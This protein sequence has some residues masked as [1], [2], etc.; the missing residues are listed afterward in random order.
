MLKHIFTVPAY[1]HPP[2]LQEKRLLNRGYWQIFGGEY[3][4]DKKRN[5]GS[6]V[7]FGWNVRLSLPLIEEGC[8]ALSCSFS[9]QEARN[10]IWASM[11]HWGKWKKRMGANSSSKRPVFDEKEDGKYWKKE[12]RCL[13]IWYIVYF[14]T[15]LCL[16]CLKWALA[17]HITTDFTETEA[18]LSKFELM[19]STVAAEAS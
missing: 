3:L 1:T 17:C 11:F 16:N 8:P 12:F 13:N 2:L 6:C 19:S 5:N 14:F 7:F 10:A 18:K 15:A 9:F 4:T